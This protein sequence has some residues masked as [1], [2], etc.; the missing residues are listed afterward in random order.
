M[1]HSNNWGVAKDG[2]RGFRGWYRNECMSKASAGYYATLA[3]ARTAAKAAYDSQFTIRSLMNT[4][5]CRGGAE[6]AT[7]E[8]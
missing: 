5:N 3:D 8:S 4:W 2:A 6:D 1:T 7:A